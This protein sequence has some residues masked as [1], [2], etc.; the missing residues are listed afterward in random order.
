MSSTRSTASDTCASARAALA[1]SSARSRASSSDAYRTS[2]PLGNL[3][4]KRGRD[5]EREEARDDEHGERPV[6]RRP[7][8]LAGRR[9][10]VVDAGLHERGRA[11]E[12]RRERRALEHVLLG[13]LLTLLAVGD[14]HDQAV[15]EAVQRDGLPC[16][17]CGGARRGARARA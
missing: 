14:E 9:L 12:A 8:L 13:E 6:Q 7:L 15:V 16:A 10:E 4:E 17:P 5:G 3:D 1:P 2:Q 11:A